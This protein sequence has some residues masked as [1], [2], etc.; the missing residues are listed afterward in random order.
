MV[1]ERLGATPLGADGCR[2]VVWA[3]N[4]ERVEVCLEAPDGRTVPTV[5]DDRG[6]FTVT[7]DSVA[8]AAR[9][10]YRLDG[11]KLRPDPASRSQPEGV[12][13]PSA[14]VDPAFP[15]QDA[16]WRGLPLERFV[17]YELHV[18]TY[19]PEGTFDAIIPHLDRLKELGVTAVEIMPVAQFPGTRNWGYDG[20]DLFAAQHSYGGPDGLRRLVDACH[21]RGL[22]AVLDC[23][24]NH[25]G[26]EGNYLWD[27]GPYF[28]DRYHT[29]WGA[30]VNFDGPYSDEVRRFFIANALQWLDEFHLDALRLDAI[31][32]IR[33]FS[34]YP[35]LRQLAD[36]V[37]ARAAE[38][39]QPKYLIAESDMNDVRVV[40]FDRPYE[41]AMDAQWSDSFHHAL[42]VALTDERG[43][44]YVDYNGVADLATAYRRSFVYTGQYSKHRRR[45]HG[46]DPLP[47]RGAQF[48]ICAQN[49]DQVGNRAVGDRLSGLVP[50]DGLKLAAGAV[51]LAPYIPLLFMGEEYGEPAPFQFF[52]NHGDESLIEAVRT[53]RREEFVA[54]AWAGE[55]P[56]PD[57][58]ETFARSRLGHH[59][60]Q[61]GSTHAVL[62]EFYR[63]LLRLRRELPALAA[64]DLE[65][66]DVAA[67]EA[68]K[69]LT[70]HRWHG[71]H[72]I[73]AFFNFSDQTQTVNLMPSE[74]LAI[75]YRRSLSL[76]P[77]LDSGDPRWLGP[78]N[79][80]LAIA[81]HERDAAITVTLHPHS[82]MLCGTPIEGTQDP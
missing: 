50:F 23:V 3:P 10:R 21:Q 59:D 52:T 71:K 48:V 62:R 6:Y 55:V 15:W 57:D 51:L 9:Y 29:P 70:L 2:F 4:C 20:V 1:L 7:V 32:T 14:V 37:H 68:T 56:D 38:I 46:N 54:F 72:H 17:I 79:A 53:G 28:T 25:L 69:T 76:R 44:Y 31:D 22:A 80:T 67:D 8:P 39:G 61:E 36:T 33:D 42:H 82:F 73:V 81:E 27:Y 16:D 30:A 60:Q 26:P 41:Y 24:Y 78:G 45:R 12:H 34:A 77:M 58:P 65:T 66:L 75:P 11:E 47:A 13:G 74:A 40:R 35:F 49:H 64:L 43:G 5:R 63:E 19:T 18:G